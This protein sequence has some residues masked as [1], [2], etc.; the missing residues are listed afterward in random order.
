MPNS[1]ISFSLAIGLTCLS[2]HAEGDSFFDLFSNDYSPTYDLVIEELDYTKQPIPGEASGL[3][4]FSRFKMIGDSVSVNIDNDGGIFDSQIYVA[5][6]MAGFKGPHAQ[7]AYRMRPKDFKYVDSFEWLKLNNIEF[8]MDR[9]LIHLQGHQFAMKEPRTTLFAKNFNL[10]CDRHP[11]YL[12]NDGDGF[13][14]GCLNSSIASPLESR[15]FPIEY[16]LKSEDQSMELSRISGTFTYFE[17]SHDRFHVKANRVDATIQEMTEIMADNIDVKC[18]KKS[19]LIHIDEENL[20]YPC[21]NDISYQSRR[22]DLKLHSEEVEGEIDKINILNPT[23]LHS[24][25]G[26]DFKSD[27]FDYV[28][29]TTNF[30]TNAVSMKCDPAM[31]SPD[32]VGSFFQSCLETGRIGSKKED[33]LGIEFTIDEPATAEAEPFYL[34]LKGKIESLLTRK[35]SLQLSS[36]KMDLGIDKNLFFKMN[37]VEWNCGKK[38]GKRELDIPLLLEECKDDSHIQINDVLINHFTNIEDPVQYL[39][40]PDTIISGNTVVEAGV[41]HMT[42]LAKNTIKF[43]EGLNLR[44][45]KQKEA[46]LFKIEDLIEGCAKN[47]VIELPKLYTSEQDIDP[48][49]ILAER[50]NIENLRNNIRKPSIT[51][52]KAVITNGKIEVSLEAKVMGIKPNV[53]FSGPVNWDKEARILTIKVEK[54]KLPLI[55]NNKM[56]FRMILRNLIE[57]DL[58]EINDK[59]E[60]RINL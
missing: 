39:V 28:S 26:L 5:N 23:A 1:L 53:Y 27:F 59:T 21:L 13:I 56:L 17:G 7:F 9:S 3:F 42:M 55:L 4:R 14:A 38:E 44:C 49:V 41:P 37:Q 12:L 45:Q 30:K 15:G 22:L 57:G 60:I 18:H 40:K 6:N 58:V 43:F 32:D 46:D 48:K 29:K 25:E 16:I 8:K 24:S 50:T 11:D 19:D 36:S 34:N 20:L 47:A 54:L 35:S 33:H 52:V 51:D 10:D 31:G 2:A